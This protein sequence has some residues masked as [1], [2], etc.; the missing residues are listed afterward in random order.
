MACHTQSHT[1]NFKTNHN[2]FPV[3]PMT[4]I[5]CWSHMSTLR[6]NRNYIKTFASPSRNNDEK[7]KE[8]KQQEEVDNDLRVC[9]LNLLP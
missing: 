1:Q 7:K 6:T 2:N 9:M 3:R 8:K 5:R 4:V